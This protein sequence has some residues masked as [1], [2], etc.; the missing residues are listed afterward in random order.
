MV[1]KVG[2]DVEHSDTRDTT[3]PNS[4]RQVGLDAKHWYDDFITQLP[5]ELKLTMPPTD[6]GGRGYSDEYVAEAMKELRYKK[7]A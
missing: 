4:D 3:Q 2:L 1:K 7:A 5:F 6:R